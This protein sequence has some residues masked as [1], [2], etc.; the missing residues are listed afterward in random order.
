MKNNP[1]EDLYELSEE[2]LEE[3]YAK[4]KKERTDGSAM[5]RIAEIRGLMA[6]PMKIDMCK[7]GEDYIKLAEEVRDAYQRLLEMKGDKMN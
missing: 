2:L 4:L 3:S 1:F 6:I 7:T 5:R